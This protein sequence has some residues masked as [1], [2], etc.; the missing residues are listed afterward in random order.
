MTLSGLFVVTLT[1]VAVGLAANELLGLGASGPVFAVQ[2]FLHWGLLVIV[3][4]REGFLSSPPWE[5]SW[6]RVKV[7]TLLVAISSMAL[8]LRIGFAQ[9]HLLGDGVSSLPYSLSWICA[10]AELVSIPGLFLVRAV[11]RTEL[12]SGIQTVYGFGLF[13]DLH[14]VYSLV[15]VGSH[16]FDL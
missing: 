11:R 7:G 13:L 1:T 16:G 2:L 5:T 14:I 12:G 8:G 4:M 3:S 15:M 9:M 6:S 10:A